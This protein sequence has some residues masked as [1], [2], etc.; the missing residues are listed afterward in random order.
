MIFSKIFKIFLLFFLFSACAVD[1]MGNYYNLNSKCKVEFAPMC[2]LFAPIFMDYALNIDKQL[3]N[4]FP[5]QQNKSIAASKRKFTIF[6][7]ENPENSLEV[8]QEKNN[9]T[10]TIGGISPNF[11]NDYDFLHNFFTATALQYMPENPQIAAAP[12]KIPHWIFLALHAKIKNS[13]AGQKIMRSQHR[14][15]GM[16]FFL[17]ENFFPDH[18]RIEAC[19]G[20]LMSNIELFLFQDYCRFLLDLSLK[21]SPKNNIAPAL[22]LH[23][24]YSA[25]TISDPALFQ[26]VIINPLQRQAKEHL[27]RICDDPAKYTEKE[28]MDIFLKFNAE[29][30]AFSLNEPAS[31]KFLKQRFAEFQ[32]VRFIELDKNNKPT[33]KI[34]ESSI[35]HLPEL[36]KQYPIADKVL[37]QKRGELLFIRSIAGSFFT[38]ELNELLDKFINIKDSWL[39]GTNQSAIKESVA[40]INSRIDQFA[41]VEDFL[42][43]SETELLSPFQVFPREFFIAGELRNNTDPEDFIKI[44]DKVEKEYLD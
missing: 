25:N 28:Q 1:L 6:I 8:K 34:I 22:Y 3:Q 18:I 44:L 42:K 39:F 2:E 19:N 14:I 7:S 29:R 35:E 10:I 12:P 13:F 36:I 33:G 26:R 5:K 27:R 16:K 23:E 41:A 21:Y 37:Q 32:K 11:Q 43:K 15:E 40:K 24:I 17:Y 30:L 31:A 38:E 4:I 20:K 9:I